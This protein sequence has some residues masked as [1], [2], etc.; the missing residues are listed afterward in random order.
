MQRESLSRLNEKAKNCAVEK[1]MIRGI[2]KQ[3]EY[4]KPVLC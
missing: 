2:I 3:D 1:K 4:L